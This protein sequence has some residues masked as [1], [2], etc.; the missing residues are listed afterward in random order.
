MEEIGPLYDAVV[1]QM[2]RVLRPQ[3]RAVLLVAEAAVLKQAIGAVGWKQER[4]VP[5]RV[6]GQRAVIMAYRKTG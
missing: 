1:K 5:V 4:F 2:D 3:G 6:L